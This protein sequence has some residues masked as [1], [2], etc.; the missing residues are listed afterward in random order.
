M[1]Y[2]DSHLEMETNRKVRAEMEYMGGVVYKRYRVFARA[3]TRLSKEEETES[4]VMREEVG[5][6]LSSPCI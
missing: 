5:A 3:I 2:I 6:M 4:A 1:E